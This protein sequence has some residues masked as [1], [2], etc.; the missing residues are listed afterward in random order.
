M[1]YPVMVGNSI[2]MSQTVELISVRWSFCFLGSQVVKNLRFKILTSLLFL[3]FLWNQTEHQHVNS[4]FCDSI[5]TKFVGAAT[6]SNLRHYFLSFSKL[7]S[8]NFFFYFSSFSYFSFCF[9]M[10]VHALT[11]ISCA[12]G[13]VEWRTSFSEREPCTIKKSKTGSVSLLPRFL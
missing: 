4:S 3:P 5:L 13:D 1:F 11:V 2:K 10:Q 8:S 9:S 12:G 7:H 6:N